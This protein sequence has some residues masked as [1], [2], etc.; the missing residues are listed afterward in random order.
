MLLV[1]LLS[2][3]MENVINRTTGSE[4]SKVTVT[5]G[6]TTGNNNTTGNITTN[7]STTGKPSDKGSTTGDNRK[8]GAN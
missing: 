3:V 5:P 7:N 6:N 4:S 8:K 1:I 2:Q